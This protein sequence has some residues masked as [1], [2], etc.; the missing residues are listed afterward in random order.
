VQT[1]G[2]ECLPLRG[3]NP[4]LNGLVEVY[5]SLKCASYT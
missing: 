3:E 1:W 2:E 5:H 4:S